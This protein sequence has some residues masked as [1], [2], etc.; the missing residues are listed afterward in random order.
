MRT[1]AWQRGVPPRRIQRSVANTVLGQVLP[2]G[3][4]KGGTGLKLRVGETGSRFT[5]D[6]DAALAGP[7][8]QFH[9]DLEDALRAGW[10]RFTGAVARDL[11]ETPTGVPG[12]YVMR[13][14]RVKMR[15]V[16][17][18]WLTIDL[19]V[20]HDEIGCAQ[21]ADLCIAPDIVALFAELGLPEPGP[22]PVMRITHQVAQ[23]LHALTSPHSD[24]VRDLV[25]LQLLTAEGRLDKVAARSV[26]VRLFR[27]R[28]RHPWPPV[29]TPTPRWESLYA[30]ASEDL[31]VVPEL[32]T[33][34]EWCRTLVADID[35]A[36]QDN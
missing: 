20:G 17:R 26:A 6:F 12:A 34:V 5:P 1:V 36:V 7:V 30:A 24:R 21:D 16:G 9:C 11:P 27:F 14:F 15:Y 2:A 29:L 32:R 18:P 4:V 22:V 8:E 35:A 23:K 13:P 10:H 28:A 25:D 31:P 33:A 19:E 3:V